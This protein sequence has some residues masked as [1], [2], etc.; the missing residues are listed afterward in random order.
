MR[1]TSVVFR[2][3][4]SPSGG[5]GHIRRCWTLASHLRNFVGRIGFIASTP[6]AAQVL[7]KAGFETCEEPSPSSIETTLR[8]LHLI[9]SKKLCVAD[10]PSLTTSDLER[11]SKAAATI[12]IDDTC[13]R[14][15]PVEMAINGSAG[16]QSLPYRGRRDTR[17]LLGSDYIML[18]PCFEHPP[19]RRWTHEPPKRILVLTGGG[20]AGPL[21]EMIVR[22][23]RGSLP[24]IRID[25]VGG[26]LGFGISKTAEQTA[27]V[28][29]HRNPDDIRSLMLAADIAVSGGGQTAYELAAT[30]TPTLG[31]LAAPNQHVNLKG[32]ASAGT[33][34]DLGSPEDP[35]FEKKLREAV[36][37][38]AGD[39][40]KRRWMGEAGRFLV[41]GKGTRRVADEILHLIEE[42]ELTRS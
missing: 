11:L 30:A 31:I 20:E 14:E 2:V 25:V 36:L 38:L 8:V 39:P 32:L 34:Q 18:R 10:D 26:P 12:C 24:K 40:H 27:G 3:A 13:E 37:H 33:L 5:F 23:V 16:A 1:E 9:P 29:A 35:A 19:Q 22:I 42:K 4:G 41:D 6:E 21:S 7:R 28:T 17:F 15:F